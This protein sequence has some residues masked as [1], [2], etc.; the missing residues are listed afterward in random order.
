MTALSIICARGGSVGVPGKNSRLLCGRPLITYTIEQALQTPEI[1]MVVVST[2]D[3]TIADIAKDCGAEVP[4]KRPVH[5]ASNEASKLDVI[6]HAVLEMESLGVD[7]TTIVDLDPT[8]PLRTIQDIQACIAM[9]DKY[10]DVVITTCEAQKNPYFNMV[11]YI[12]KEYVKLVKPMNKR[13]VARQLAP[14]V[15]EM[16]ASIYVWHR[17]TFSSGLWNGKTKNYIMPVERSIDIDSPI[18]FAL[19]ELLMQK[20]NNV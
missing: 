17:H 3:D 1:D 4:F 6:D 11:E 19:V 20:K 18:D 13:V 16:N 8:S 15:Y 2:D 7:V 12:D 14:K 10:T 5:L 9:L